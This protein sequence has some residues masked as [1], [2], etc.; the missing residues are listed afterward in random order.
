MLKSTMEWV[1]LTLLASAVI[2][3]F[4]EG[5]SNKPKIRLVI[6]VLIV[7]SSLTICV[8]Q[9]KMWVTELTLGGIWALLNLIL[10]FRPSFMQ[11]AF[12][13]MKQMSG[14]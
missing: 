9:S 4:V 14:K 13:K 3:Q 1:A 8:R 5:F 6:V 12:R 11:D 10:Y 7:A 2:L